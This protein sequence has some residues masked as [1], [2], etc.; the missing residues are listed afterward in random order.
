MRTLNELHTLHDTVRKLGQQAERATD[1]A[2]SL[3]RCGGYTDI[4]EWHRESIHYRIDTANLLADAM[5]EFG[6]TI[7]GILAAR[8]D[9]LAHEAMT[10]EVLKRAELGAFVKLEPAEGGKV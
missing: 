5:Q 6:P 8:Q 9:V 2:N 10:Q 7:L 1:M 4:F 3:R